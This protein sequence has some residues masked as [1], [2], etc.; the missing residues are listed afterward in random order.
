MAETFGNNYITISDDDGKEYVFEHLDTIMMDDV[1][2][3]ACLP[4]DVKEDDPAYGIVILK[5]EEDES[6]ELYL[7]VPEEEEEEK[8]YDE[9]M[10][11]LYEEWEEEPED[12]EE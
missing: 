1:F 2:Y 7:S 5:Q 10:R 9:Y 3:L 6:G 11:R 4:T 12:E 8:A